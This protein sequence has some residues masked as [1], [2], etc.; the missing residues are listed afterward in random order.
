M[1]S[2]FIAPSTGSYAFCFDNTM[3]RWT[4]KVV[5][6]ELEVSSSVEEDRQASSGQ[7]PQEV[8]GMQKRMSKTYIIL[9]QVEEL[10]KY[11][12]IREHR[13]R[14]SESCMVLCCLCGQ[15]VCVWARSC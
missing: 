2:Q 6:F 10:Q 1:H 13:H 7:V 8:D 11:N 14:D 3:S 9:E 15:S 5:D 4:A 12:H